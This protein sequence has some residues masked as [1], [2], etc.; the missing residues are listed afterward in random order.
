MA[1]GKH[2]TITCMDTKYM[3][4]LN[5]DLQL[6]DFSIKWILHYRMYSSLSTYIFKHFLLWTV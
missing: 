6:C 3:C 4:D 1:K 2:K 5:K